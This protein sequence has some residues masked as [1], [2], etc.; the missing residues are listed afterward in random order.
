VGSPDSVAVLDRRTSLCSTASP[1]LRLRRQAAV[2]L[3]KTRCQDLLSRRGGPGRL[4][5]IHAAAEAASPVMPP[6]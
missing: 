4:A 5:A 6:T 1:M 3:A 2:D